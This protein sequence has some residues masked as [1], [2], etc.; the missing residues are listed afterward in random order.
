MKEYYIN[1]EER[2]IWYLIY[3]YVM[4]YQLESIHDALDMY[5]DECKINKNKLYIRK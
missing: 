1:T 3:E 2:F 5:V 4:K